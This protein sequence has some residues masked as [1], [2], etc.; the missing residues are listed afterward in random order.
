MPRPSANYHL[1][2][3]IWSRLVFEGGVQLFTADCLF[4]IYL[5]NVTRTRIVGQAAFLVFL[6]CA[7]LKNKAGAK[8]QTV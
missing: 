1:V 5:R 8:W 2:R 4:Y 6:Y 7:A 3:F